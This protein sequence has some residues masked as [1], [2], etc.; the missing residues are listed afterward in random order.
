[1]LQPMRIYKAFVLS[2]IIAGLFYACDKPAEEEVNAESE[3]FILSIQ[4]DG[5]LEKTKSTEKEKCFEYVYPTT[6]TMPDASTVTIEKDED[7]S[8]V[9]DWFTANPKSKEK[10]VIK[11]PVDLKFKEGVVKTISNADEMKKVWAY[12]NGGKEKAKKCF[13]YVFP[14]SFTMPDKTTITVNNDKD[15]GG[16]KEWYANNPDSKEKYTLNYPVQLKFKDGS[17]K[18][19]QNEEEMKAVKAYCYGKKTDEKTSKTDKSSK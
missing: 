19:I 12:C 16:L 3:S 15:W 2:I 11:F 6:F 18:T 10:P 7:W 4:E 8:V 1:M 14:V 9:K 5:K 13:W 17:I